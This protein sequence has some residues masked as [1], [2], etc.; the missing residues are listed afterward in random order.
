MIALSL[1][2]F[3][4]VVKQYKAVNFKNVEFTVPLMFTILY[5]AT[6]VYDYASW[7]NTYALSIS[8]FF[9]VIFTAMPYLIFFADRFDRYRGTFAGKPWLETKAEME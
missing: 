5:T 3:I 9:I 1:A 7:Y 8:G 6:A 2:C 4:F